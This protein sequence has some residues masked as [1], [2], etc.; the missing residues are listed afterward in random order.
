MSLKFHLK[1]VKYCVFLLLCFS[2]K[3]TRD[4]TPV[5]GE[6]Q[7]HLDEGVRAEATT[8]D[9]IFPILVKREDCQLNILR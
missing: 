8:L 7:S 2:I 1:V 5:I 4:C 3:S 9:E 6:L